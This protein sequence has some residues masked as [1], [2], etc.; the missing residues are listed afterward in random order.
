MNCPQCNQPLENG[1]LF[2]G[3]CGLAL[4]AAPLPPPVYS[5]PVIAL[6]PVLANPLSAPGS[7]GS[8]VVPPAASVMAIP[9]Y[10]LRPAQPA[11][12]KLILA[13][14]CGIVGSI[15]A[16]FMAILGIALGVTG[17]VLATTAPRSTRPKL[18]IAGLVMS[19]LAIIVGLG[20]W[21]SIIADG[22]NLATGQ[23]GASSKSLTGVAG[24]TTPCY[25]FSLANNTKLNVENTSAACSLNVYN[26]S[27]LATSSEI[28][29]VLSSTEPSVSRTNFASVSKAAIE[30]DIRQ[31]LPSFVITSEQAGR[32]AD[33]PAYFVNATDRATNV[34]FQ[35]STVLHATS[36]GDNLF[37][38]IH[39]T[40]GTTTDL[41][42]LEANWQWK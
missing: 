11:R 21:V 29:K 16:L 30:Q 14:V 33:S 7:I 39:A 38:L 8:P 27:S 1:A 28:Y 36:R 18:K 4:S 9:S 15:G 20:V 5:A 24:T 40:S 19:I 12:T 32:F 3:N 13:L 34:A 10:A 35:E 41:A 2:C 6:A 42:Q 22:A 31:S 26:A 17:I 25:S 37:V 23:S